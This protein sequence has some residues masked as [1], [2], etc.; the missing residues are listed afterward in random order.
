[1]N[2][3]AT[4]EKYARGIEWLRQYGI[5]TFGSFITGFPGE[6]EET[7]NETIDFIKQ[8]KPDYYRSQLWYCE[9]GT[10]IQNERIKYQIEGEGFVWKHATM[11]SLEA[12]DHI[13]R[14][15]LEI[16]ESIWLPQWSFDFWIV[17][18]LLGKGI[19]LSRFKEFMALAHKLL[20]LE[21]AYVPAKQKQLKQQEYFQQM[22]RQFGHLADGVSQTQIEACDG[23][24]H[25]QLPPQFR[26][27][28]SA[29]R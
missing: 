1:M 10:P 20:A 23:P 25:A 14:M 13:D 7:V 18:Y 26:R 17:P 3:A 5:M 21:I 29:E 8:A 9:P 19:S 11:D 2:K 12:A 15:F 27:L 24:T 4:I 22:V 28:L 16:N 6:T